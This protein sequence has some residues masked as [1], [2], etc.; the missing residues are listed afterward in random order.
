MELIPSFLASNAK[1]LI[2]KNKDK[3]MEKIKKV[4]DF[5][6]DHTFILEENEDE[7]KIIKERHRLG[8]VLS[9]SKICVPGFNEDF[10]VKKV[11]EPIDIDTDKKKILGENLEIMIK[12]MIS[13]PLHTFEKDLHF[14]KLKEIFSLQG[15]DNFIMKKE[16]LMSLVNYTNTF[17]PSKFVPSERLKCGSLVGITDFRVGDK[18]YDVR[19][20]KNINKRDFYQLHIYSLM[21]KEI[22]G[23]EIKKLIILSPINGEEYIMKVRPGGVKDKILELYR[24]IV[25]DESF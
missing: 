11:F 15:E 22:L 13:N 6:N 21:L 10:K 16:Q 7:I 24:N 8:G 17:D 25:Y 14:N 19:N 5:Y 2:I 12:T 20:K 4:L 23:I 3:E 1:S 9:A 18:L